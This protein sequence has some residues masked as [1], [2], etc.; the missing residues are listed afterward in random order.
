VKR[1]GDRGELL[2][3]HSG[4]GSGQLGQAKV[5]NIRNNGPMTWSIEVFEP[6]LA[7]PPIIDDPDEFLPKSLP[8]VELLLYLGESP[9]TAQLLPAIARKCRARSVIAPVDNSAWLPSG[10][11]TQI[12]KELGDAGIASVFP[13][14]FCTLTEASYNYRRS[15]EGYEDLLIA[16]FAKH[17]GMP[18]VE[19]AV[20]P[21]SKK[22]EKVDV[23]RDAACG[24]T[25]Y[26]AQGL[27]G[28]SAD[29]AEF[30]AGMLHHHY[31]CLAAMTVEHIDD[32]LDDTL[33]HVAGYI[34]RDSVAEQVK[35]FKKPAVYL[36]GEGYVSG[37]EGEKQG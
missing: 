21:N 9:S 3:A 23:I 30:E 34:I 12:K 14:P 32:R 26:V 13:K 1:T 4:G 27:I 31:P 29:D 17:F 20:N 18:Q 11:A 5:E 10:L 37:D 16:E 19:V 35:T 6:P 8:H 28:V 22:I 15:A 2:H 36:K 24:N 7:L 33:M 25:R